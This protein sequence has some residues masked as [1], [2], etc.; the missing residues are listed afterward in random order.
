MTVNIICTSKPIDGLLYY[1]YEYCCLLNSLGVAA[2]LI[3]VCH[4]R[5]TPDSYRAA[6]KN[7]YTVFDYV[8]FDQYYPGPNDVALV[9]GR[10]MITLS[11]QAFKDYSAGQQETLRAVFGSKIISVYSENHPEL[12]PKALAFYKPQQVVDL[13]DREVYP[14]G[15]GEHFEKTI[16][17][18][19]YKPHVDSVQFRY[20]FQGSN[21]EYYA[22]AEKFIDQF[23]DYGILAYRE[24]YIN[25]TL[26]NIF[27]PIENL[28]G[29]FDTYVY[30]KETFDP[31][32]RI[33]QECRYFNKGLIYLRDPAIHD[34]G[35]VYY[36]RD[37][38]EPDVGPIL[39]ALEKLQ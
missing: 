10:S 26:N 13:C 14:E 37:I 30:A 11:W 19:L 29:I 39:A 9:L 32:P 18:D 36:Q 35:S 4:R 15:V 25:P 5:Y 6:I 34:G 31:A 33:V 3:I 22:T 21:A 28:L 23:P 8:Q 1:S 2:R 20:L 24:K 38:R 7:K 27:A 17:F 12:Y 16:W